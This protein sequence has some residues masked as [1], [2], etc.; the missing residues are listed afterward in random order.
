MFI[1]TIN[2]GIDVFFIH[3]TYT[4]WVKMAVTVILQ[5]SNQHF[6]NL[7]NAMDK[8]SPSL[9]KRSRWQFHLEN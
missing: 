9:S 3:F 8:M 4:V 2:M 7:C 5:H 6:N 1:I